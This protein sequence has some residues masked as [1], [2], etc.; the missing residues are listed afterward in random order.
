MSHETTKKTCTVRTTN[1]APSKSRF[2]EVNVYVSITKGCKKLCLL[3]H[4]VRIQVHTIQ[5]GR[6]RPVTALDERHI[7]TV[8]ALLVMD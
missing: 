7:T 5:S 2:C 1:I 4:T 3:Y 8:R 6:E